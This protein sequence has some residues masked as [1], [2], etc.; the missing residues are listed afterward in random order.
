MTRGEEIMWLRIYELRYYA[1]NADRYAKKIFLGVLYGKCFIL[2][3]M[4]HCGHVKHI[5]KNDKEIRI[6]LAKIK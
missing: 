4:T 3:K 5:P 6:S 1:C 2:E